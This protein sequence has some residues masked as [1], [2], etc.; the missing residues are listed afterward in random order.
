MVSERYE[1]APITNR[2]VTNLTTLAHYE[3]LGVS[4][5][6]TRRHRWAVVRHERNA[7]LLGIPYEIRKAYGYDYERSKA[8]HMVALGRTN[9]RRMGITSDADICP[10]D[11]QH[12][13]E[14]N[15]HVIETYCAD[16]H[17][18]ID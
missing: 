17:E 11:G 13:Y 5:S 9:C 3:R 4:T 7:L 16:C 8:S 14:R 18:R 2:T 10:H 15:G 12:D 6:T 1:R